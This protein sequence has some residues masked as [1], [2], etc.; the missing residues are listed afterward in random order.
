MIRFDEITVQYP[1]RGSPSLLEANFE[2]AEGEL[3]LVIGPTGSGKS[4]LLK[5]MNNL[6]PFFTGGQRSGSIHIAGRDTS[7]LL[8]RELAD[9]VGY[10]GQNPLAGFVTD[11]VEEELAY[12]MEQLGVDPSE[13]RRRVEET[14]DLLGIADLRARPLRLLSGGQQQRVAI[15]A[16][17]VTSPDVLVLDE[18]T[19]ALDPLGAEEVLAVLR[20][21]VNDLGTT[22]VVAEHRMERVVEFADSVALLQSDATVA[23]G[24]TREVLT[25]S[26]ITPPLVELG[27]ELSWEPLP[28]TIRDGRRKAAPQR[29]K[30]QSNPP[31]TPPT[32]KPGKTMLNAQGMIVAYPQLIA[33]KDVD[34]VLHQGEVTALMGRNGCGKSSL[35]WAIQGSGKRTAGQVNAEGPISLVPQTASDLLYLSSVTEE[36]VASDEAAR[37]PS[38]HTMTLLTQ[39]VGGLTPQAH[40][41]DL[42]EG[43]QLALV[44]A[45]ELARNPTIWLLDE[46]TRGLDYAAKAHLAETLRCLAQA[47]HSVLLATHDVE[48]VAA[49]CDRVVVMAEGEVVTDGTARQ[50]LTNSPLLAT[51]VAKVAAPIELLTARE[52][53]DAS[54][55]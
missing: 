14:L 13:M 32:P 30:W 45:C 39:M 43:Q 5:C 34:L 46:P 29:R 37:Q 49:T 42:S 38:G 21:L 16:A 55:S 18:P 4:T 23:Y 35:L 7:K 31:S 52:F 27:N 9:V 36:C 53:I 10:V 12:S 22:I 47:G 40:P 33:V 54:R 3:C 51:Q 44:L 28:L 26:P 41:R 48:M 2:I 50:V 19:S 24:P 17:L 15:G 1:H 20:R 6:V 11:V 8:P 25:T